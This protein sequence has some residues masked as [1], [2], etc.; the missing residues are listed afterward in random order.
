M[1]ACATISN[2]KVNERHVGFLQEDRDR[3]QEQQVHLHYGDPHWVYYQYRLAK[4][5]KRTR[6][7]IYAK[8]NCSCSQLQE[9]C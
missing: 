5:D 8:G 6:D 2:L 3:R 1:C 4:G 9:R 7:A